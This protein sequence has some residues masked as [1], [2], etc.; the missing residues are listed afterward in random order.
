MAVGIGASAAAGSP[1]HGVHVG[2]GLVT[3]D[4]VIA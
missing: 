1:P 3:Q 4:R 2:A